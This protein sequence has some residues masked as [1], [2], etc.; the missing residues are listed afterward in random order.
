MDAKRPTPRPI[1]IKM[2]KI[3]DNKRILKA[4]KE[5]SYPQGLPISLSADF[6]KDILHARMD[7]QEILKVMKSWDLLPRL[8]CPGKLSFR[9]EG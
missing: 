8:L 5:A 7:W 2:S 9:N 1:I 6:S 3:K 4:A